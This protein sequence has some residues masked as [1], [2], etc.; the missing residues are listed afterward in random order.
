MHCT[1]TANRSRR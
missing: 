1:R